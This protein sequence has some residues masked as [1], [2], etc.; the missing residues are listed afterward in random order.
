MFRTS[1]VNSQGESF[2][3][4]MVCITC[5]GV[6]SQVDRRESRVYWDTLFCF[7]HPPDRVQKQALLSSYPPGCVRTHSPVS[8]IHQGVFDVI[9]GCVESDTGIPF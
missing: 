1:W 4:G 5:I 9:M 8:S 7:F 2:I 3:C 6:A